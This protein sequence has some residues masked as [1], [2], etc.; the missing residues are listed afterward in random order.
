MS[1]KVEFK[2]YINHDTFKIEP[3]N[4]ETVRYVNGVCTDLELGSGENV[5][6]KGGLPKIRD[7][8][9]LEVKPEGLKKLRYGPS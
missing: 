2:K 1:E 5:R 6:V 3:E 9:G 4:V 8:L 7:K